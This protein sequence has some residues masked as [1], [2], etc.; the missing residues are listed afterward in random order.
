MKS[1]S[2][3]IQMKAT[4]QYFTQVQFLTLYKMVWLLS[5]QIKPVSVTIQVKVVDGHMTYTNY[6][7]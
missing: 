7:F 4:E 6:F 5:L 1:G 2:V 3:T